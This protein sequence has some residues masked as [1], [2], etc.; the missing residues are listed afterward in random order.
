MLGALFVFLEEATAC[1][2]SASVDLV[3]PPCQDM[4]SSKN[5]TGVHLKW[6]L[7]LFNFR[8]TCLQ[9][10]ST[11]HNVSSWSFPLASYLATCLLLGLLQMAAFCI[12]ICQ[13]DMQMLWDMMVFHPV[14]DYDNQKSHVQEKDT[15]HCLILAVYH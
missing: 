5:G 8:S 10:F 11:L 12:Y 4:I 1:V 9:I 13:I 6:H 3:F 14:L 15:L 7:S 2:P